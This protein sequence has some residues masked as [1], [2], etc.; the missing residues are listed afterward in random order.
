[1]PSKEDDKH[2]READ[3]TKQHANHKG[4]QYVDNTRKAKEAKKSGSEANDSNNQATSQRTDYKSATGCTE[5]WEDPEHLKKNMQAYKTFKGQSQESEKDGGDQG[6]KRTHAA[7]ASSPNKKQKND[8]PVGAA[9]S[10]TRVP[11]KGQKVQWHALPG[12]VD[13]EVVEVVYEEKEIE[14]KK[15]EASKEDPRIVLKSEASGKICVHKPSA[16]YFD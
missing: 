15:V 7:K 9:G 3:E 10:I 11:K 6:K 13:G 1:M 14:G 2:S 16:V 5:H 8:E 12:Y 4:K